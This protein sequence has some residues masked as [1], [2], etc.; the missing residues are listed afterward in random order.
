[1]RGEWKIDNFCSSHCCT[2]SVRLW[3]GARSVLDTPARP[4]CLP[5]S[6]PSFLTTAFAPI[7]LS[8]VISNL[9]YILLGPKPESYPPYQLDSRWFDLPRS[10]P[11]ME[12]VPTKVKQSRHFS[13]R[14][15][16]RHYIRMHPYDLS[17]KKANLTGGSSVCRSGRQQSISV[18][19]EIGVS[20]RQRLSKS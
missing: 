17:S 5:A 13:C 2:S 12:S 15:I 14:V 4:A 18:R 1:M 20:Y 7:M 9:S 10:N 16:L 11:T 6:F 19:I 3:S 8:F